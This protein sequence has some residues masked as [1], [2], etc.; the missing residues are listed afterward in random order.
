MISRTEEQ[1]KWL[2]TLIEKEHNE[3]NS[4]FNKLSNEI[5]MIK[6]NN[7]MDSSESSLLNLN[8]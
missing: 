4:S 3:I 7:S 6:S 1:K 8:Q 2:L 5:N